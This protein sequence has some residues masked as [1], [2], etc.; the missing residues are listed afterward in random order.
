MGAF[1][2]S[3][4]HYPILVAIMI[5]VAIPVFCPEE[6]LWVIRKLDRKIFK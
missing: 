3:W 1:L 5:L 6:T 2:N 4:V